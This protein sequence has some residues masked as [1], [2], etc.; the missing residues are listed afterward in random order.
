MMTQT[1]SEIHSLVDQLRVLSDECEW[2]EFKHN[3]SNP[4]EI[5]TYIS[6]LA[7]SSALIGRNKAYMIWGI[8]D[9]T[10]EIIGT[11]FKPSTAKAGNKGNNSNQELES[12]LINHL[13][14]QV[15][16]NFIEVVIEGKD[17]VI[18]EIQPAYAYPVRFKNDAYIRIGTYKKKLEGYPEK[19]R[20]L[21]EKL[22]HLPFEKR[23]C[24][25]SLSAEQ[26][27]LRLDYGIYFRLIGMQL[28][29]TQAAI[30]ATLCADGLCCSMDNG[31]YAITNLGAILLAN[32]I[33]SFGRFKKKALR[34]IKYFGNNRTQT[35]KEHIFTKGYGLIFEDGLD[36]INAWLPSNE[37]IGRALRHEV[38]IFPEVAL[39]ELVANALIHQDFSIPGMGPLVEIFENRI[40]ISSPGKPLVSVLRFIDE[41]PRSRNEDLA[42]LM[43]R[44]G[45]CEERGSGI[46]KVVF[47]IELYQLPPPDFREN[48]NST[49]VVLF[50]PSKT[51]R[52]SKEEKIRACYQHACLQWVSGEQ[53][54]N[55]SLRTRFAI[56]D[57]N[58]PLAS[59]I[60]KQTIEE[61]LIKPYGELY[62][63]KAAKYVPFWA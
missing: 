24:L 50:S 18:L 40:E 3:D 37:E 29:T 63:K 60:I 27:L 31:S 55:S 2:I 39:R 33:N 46:D 15:E 49:V 58:Y 6:A 7:N 9:G 11:N 23:L 4:E 12:W 28:P 22:M 43:R 1:P 16:I 17:V 20:S 53:M 56:E 34:V 8:K 61:G 41:P 44:M 59:R 21:W 57:S 14:P 25:E 45:I 19:S 10:H 13:E 62:S 26:V 54:T 32:D 36:Y 30:L 51:H 5:G 48:E 47:Q 38:R 42:A 52:L 35:L